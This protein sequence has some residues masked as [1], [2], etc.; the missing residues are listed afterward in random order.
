M[1]RLLDWF[2]DLFPDDTRPETVQRWRRNVAVTLMALTV[3]L[4]WVTLSLF[5]DMPP[6]GKV[7]IAA[8][9]EHKIDMKVE[10]AVEPVKKQIAEL[11]ATLKSNTDQS[12]SLM[13][14]FSYAQLMERVRR[15]C[16]SID[17][18]ERDRLLREINI[19]LGTYASAADDPNFRP[20]GCNEL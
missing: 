16:K 18:D 5:Y 1:E 19:F 11:S 6:L 4:T 2:M 12:K 10:A 7:A 15:R 8:D 13:A 3:L 14:A 9:V 20:P 17:I